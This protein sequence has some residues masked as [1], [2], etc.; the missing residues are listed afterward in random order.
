VDYS[1]VTSSMLKM[2]PYCLNSH[3]TISLVLL[4]TETLVPVILLF[5]HN[6][7]ETFSSP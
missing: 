3:G 4:Q 2:Q 7:Q 5:W 1:T 6:V